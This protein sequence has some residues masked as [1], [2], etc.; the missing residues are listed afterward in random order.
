[1]YAFFAEPSAHDTGTEFFYCAWTGHWADGQGQ[2]DDEGEQLRKNG[3]H[4]CNM[5]KNPTAW[6]LPLHDRCRAV[7]SVLSALS[8]C[9]SVYCSN[10]FVFLCIAHIC[11]TAV[12]CLLSSLLSPLLSALEKL[13]I[14]GAMLKKKKL[15]PLP[16]NRRSQNPKYGV[17]VRKTYSNRFQTAQYFL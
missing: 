1:L 8:Y 17:I 15:L 16:K 3:K 13:N 14:S 9:F 4:A 6:A 12:C 10:F 5:Q 2:L 11:L 7:N